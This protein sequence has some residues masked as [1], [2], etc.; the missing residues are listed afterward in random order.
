MTR[1]LPPLPPPHPASH[2][3]SGCFF[4][5]SF[6]RC[7]AHCT[8]TAFFL[9]CK[10]RPPSV[11]SSLGG[12]QFLHFAPDIRKTE[13]RRAI[14]QFLHYTS[15]DK[16]TYESLWPI[17]NPPCARGLP[18]TPTERPRRRGER[19]DAF[20]VSAEL[21]ITLTAADLRINL[22]LCCLNP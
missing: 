1:S 18:R 20:W 12:G 2:S 13:S 8:A 4:V 15:T 6:P 16:L 5:V 3:S 17:P 7:R 11:A 9:K 21:P 10:T 14:E 19:I 22:W